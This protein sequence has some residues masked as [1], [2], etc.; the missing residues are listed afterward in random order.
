[1]CDAP[2]VAAVVLAAGSSRRMGVRHKLL[3]SLGG[4]QMVSLVID[5][6]LSSMAFSTTVVIGFR[7]EEIRTALEGRNVTIVENPDYDAGLAGSLKLGL[8]SLSADIDGAIIIL[9]DM[10]FVDAGLIDTLLGAFGSARGQY[11][12]VPVKSGRLG[13]PVVW[14]ARFFTEIMKLDGDSGARKILNRFAENVTAVPV[15]DDAAFF[16]VDTPSELDQAN[17]KFDRGALK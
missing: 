16:D 1:M 7:G 15:L 9:A 10:P 6:A 5:S 13:N 8:S 3:E 2:K 17:S 12:I 14:P 4:T 11:I